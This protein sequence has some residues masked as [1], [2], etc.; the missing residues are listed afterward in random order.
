MRTFCAKIL[1]VYTYSKFF[2]D[3]VP[4]KILDMKVFPCAKITPY[5]IYTLQRLKA[6]RMRDDGVVDIM[7]YQVHVLNA[8]EMATRI[9][10]SKRN[11]V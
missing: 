5:E 1:Y 10:M 3:F 9:R 8:L 4:I 11:L 7:K 6:T 2:H